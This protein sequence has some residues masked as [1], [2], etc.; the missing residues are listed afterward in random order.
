MASRRVDR[1]PSLTRGG[2]LILL[3][4][5]LDEHPLLEDSAR[6]DVATRCGPL[7]ALH[8][9]C[10]DSMSLNTWVEAVLD[11]GI[12]RVEVG[13]FMEQAPEGGRGDTYL[14]SELDDRQALGAACRPVPAR[15]RVGRVP[16]DPQHGGGFLDGEDVGVG[17]Q[18]L[19]EAEQAKEVITFAEYWKR[20]AGADPGLL[21]LDSKLTTYA[22]L[23]ELAARGITFLT[24]RQRG[25]TVLA[26]L[27]GLPASAWRTHNVKRAGCYRRPQINEQIVNLLRRP[28]P[29][30]PD[31]HPQ[32]RPPSAHPVDHQRPHYAS[33]GTSSPATPSG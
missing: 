14:S 11:W 32:H 16:S 15:Q 3:V 18:L 23:D 28:P 27:A 31:R 22:M 19:S 4:R 29:A 30:A 24:L 2:F 33:Q 25:P 1:I 12:A 17:G 9:C 21:V 8:R 13:S 10:A 6:A 20:V 7:T 26:G 5:S